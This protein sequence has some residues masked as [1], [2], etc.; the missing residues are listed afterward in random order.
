M[1]IADDALQTLSP[2][3]AA[4]IPGIH[5]Y[6]A[7]N[8]RTAR[9]FIKS[10][11]PSTVID[12]LEFSEIDK[13]TG[14]DTRLMKQ[15]IKE[16]HD[17]GIMSESGCP[18]IADPGAILVMT[19]HEA[20]A[21]VIPLTGPSSILLSLMASGLSGQHFSF[22]GYLPVKEPE[23]CKKLRELEAISA[24]ENRTQIFIETPYRNN[25]MLDDILKHCR[26]NTLLCIAQEIT[27][28]GAFIKTK[29]I[30]A[31]KAGKP[32]LEKKPAVFLLLAQ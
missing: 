27:A 8:I 28:P 13:H 17:I 20:G 7:E 5:H 23:R 25:A 9:R 24:K 3:I 2:E 32:S 11:C 6:F 10:I 14:A 22:N 29:K 30:S 16:G 4:A 15:W 21:E 31:W 19:A 12:S 1:P 26:G 18:G